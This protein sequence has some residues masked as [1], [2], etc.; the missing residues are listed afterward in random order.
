MHIYAR[1]AISYNANNPNWD[2]VDLLSQ[3]VRCKVRQYIIIVKKGQNAD[4]I[5]G[6]LLIFSI[7]RG[8]GNS[9]VGNFPTAKFG[10]FGNFGRV[11]YCGR[12]RA[13][14]G[15]VNSKALRG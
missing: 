3:I 15:G 5:A 9:N 10:N 11:I 2:R 8:V 7:Y 1:Y 14:R 12:D 4:E 6:L 13:K